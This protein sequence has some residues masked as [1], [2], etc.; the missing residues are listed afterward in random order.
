MATTSLEGIIVLY[1]SFAEP[2]R[3]SGHVGAINSHVPFVV[4]KE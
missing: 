2:I 3:T 1:A 4:N